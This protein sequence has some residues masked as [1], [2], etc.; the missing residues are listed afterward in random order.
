MQGA[1]RMTKGTNRGFALAFVPRAA[2]VLWICA[3]ALAAFL[4]PQEGEPP[5]RPPPPPGGCQISGEAFDEIIR[6]HKTSDAI[7]AAIASL[8]EEKG[9]NVSADQPAGENWLMRNS[10]VLNEEAKRPGYRRMRELLIAAELQQDF[11]ARHAALRKILRLADTPLLRHRVQ[12]EI[13]HTALRSGDPGNLSLAEAAAKAAHSEAQF[14]PKPA[15]ADA[16]L[17][18]AELALRAG[19]LRKSIDLVDRALEHDAA[20]L[21]AHLLRLDL[22]VR[23]SARQD[24]AVKARYLDRGIAS[25]FFVR[26][27]T[28]KSYVVDA[29]SAI[30][31]HHAQSDVST[32]LTFYLSSLA[33]DREGA[34]RAIAGLLAQCAGA[35]VCSAA[36]I[37]RARR[38]MNAL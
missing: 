13:A 5:P 8:C 10:G 22:V 7:A 4:P 15:R 37:E 2:V 17:V 9:V 23:L 19:Q 36:V 11:A 20:Y 30:A 26:R 35:R 31:E 14:L 1:T 21:A 28:T 29:R 6:V 24:E 12:I 18:D 25:A 27:L 3:L 38:L 32:L 16:Y 33:D 34:R